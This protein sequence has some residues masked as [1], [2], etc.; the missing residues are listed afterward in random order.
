[1]DEASIGPFYY[2]AI[3]APPEFNSRAELQRHLTFKQDKIWPLFMRNWGFE[4]WYVHIEMDVLED[5]DCVDP[6][7]SSELADITTS[8]YYELKILHFEL[9][10]QVKMVKTHR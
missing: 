10:V 1:M 2:S 7:V 4:K 3:L 9:K 6:Y 5:F 8:P